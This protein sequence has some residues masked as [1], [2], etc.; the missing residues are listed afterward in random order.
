MQGS[1]KR[2]DDMLSEA[3]NQLQSALRLLDSMNA[4]PQIGA[5]VDLAIHELHLTLARTLA[6]G[7]FT[8]ADRTGVPQ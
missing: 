4:P 6:G 5:Y 3:L 2:A 1:N 7:A 8:P